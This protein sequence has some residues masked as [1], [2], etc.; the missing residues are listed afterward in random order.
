MSFFRKI[1]ITIWR[2]WFYILIA[3]P[4]I[5]MFPFLLLFTS[6]EKYYPQFFFLARIW[7]NIIL[8]GMGFYPIVKKLE[9]PQKGKSYMFVANHTSMIDIMLMLSIVKNPFVFVGKK[10]L[11][12]FPV[13]GFFYKRTCILVDRGNVKSRNEVFQQAQRRLKQGVSI[14]I[15]PEGGVP[16]DESVLLDTFKDGAFRLAIDHQIPIVP[17]V[18]YDNKKRFSYT[19]FSGSLGKMRAK[20]L[21]FFSTENLNQTHKKQLKENVW[22]AIY[23][24]LKN[25]ET[26]A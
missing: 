16:D 22:E 14:C 19:F 2:I 15:F 10:E 7:A 12:K 25:E 23:T 13:F 9:S 4:I 5:V 3:V 6:K 1:L 8:Y 21:P 17:L 11:A 24:E 26:S 18:F 20:I